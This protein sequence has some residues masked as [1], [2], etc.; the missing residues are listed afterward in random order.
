MNPFSNLESHR[1]RIPVQVID[2]RVTHR[3]AQSNAPTW[4]L[5]HGEALV[6]G[7]ILNDAFS[8]DEWNGVGILETVTRVSPVIL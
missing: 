8:L 6:R 5:N 4:K 7:N 1:F 2:L 3:L